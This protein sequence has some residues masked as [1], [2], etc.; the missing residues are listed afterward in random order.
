MKNKYDFIYFVGD[1]Y[2]FAVA[3]GDDIHGE[4]NTSNRFSGLVSKHFELPEINVGLPGCSN[5]HIFRTIYNDVYKFINEGKKFLTVVSYTSPTRIELFH[6]KSNYPLNISDCFSFFKD[7]M[8]ES[9]DAEHCDQ[10]TIEYILAIHTLFDKFNLD[11]V[12]GWTTHRLEVPYSIPARELPNTFPEIMGQDGKFPNGYH[13][14]ILGNARIAE[15]YI[16]KITEL[17]GSR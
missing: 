11:Y 17:Y 16:K 4:I 3:Q 5:Q 15:H 13:A 6:K 8:I 2:T 12:E 14:N 7:Y 1:S 9:F 10:V